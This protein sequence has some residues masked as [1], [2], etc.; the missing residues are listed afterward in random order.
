MIYTKVY[1][2]GFTIEKNP[3][4]PTY[5]VNGMASKHTNLEAL[6]REL[7]KIGCKGNIKKS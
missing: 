4:V 6:K 3:D 7:D 2:N 5:K 1:H